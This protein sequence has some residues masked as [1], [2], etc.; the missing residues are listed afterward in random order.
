[1]GLA[2]VSAIYVLLSVQLIR[3]MLLGAI[4]TLFERRWS[5]SSTP[6]PH[7]G[8]AGYVD[9]IAVG[10]VLGAIR[11]RHQL[12]ALPL[13]VSAVLL[14]VPAARERMLQGFTTETRDTSA[15]VESQ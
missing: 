11:W 10:G 7:G 3:R 9:W 15:N 1:M 6:S 4:R 13:V 5:V 2:A 12:L 14:L 8:R